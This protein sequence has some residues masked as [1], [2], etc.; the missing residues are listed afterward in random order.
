MTKYF[1]PCTKAP[2]QTNKYYRL[3]SGGGYS[4]CI[5]GRPNY[6]KD[7]KSALNNCVGWSWGRMA[8]IEED[9]HCKVGC[10]PGRSYPGDAYMWLDYSKRRGF[11]TG[12]VPKLGAV[13]VWISRKNRRVGHVGNVETVNDDGTWGSSESGLDT[14]VSWWSRLYPKS[15]YKAGYVFQ[16]FI[17]S[18]TE[19]IPEPEPELKAGDKVRIIGEGNSQA[20]GKG[21]T[22]YGIGYV[23]YIYKIYEGSEYPY[24]V[25]FTNGVTT[26]FYKAEALE[27][28]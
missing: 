2:D 5:P 11:K 20:N 21:S 12:T 26:G 25:G 10:A 16:G 24:R 15:S 18:P 7:G 14:S 17:Y 9:P 13:A 27:K 28:I 23:R 19:W 3:I 1:K 8:E 4:P 22:A 6:S